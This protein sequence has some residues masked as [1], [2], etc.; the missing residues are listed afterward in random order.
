MYRIAVGWLTWEITESTVW[1]GII[2]F[3]ETFPLVIFSVIAG[4]LAD[5]MGYIRITV[6]AQ[7]ATAA[8]A[9][10]FAAMTLSGF[11]TIELVLIFALLK[12]WEIYL[13]IHLNLL[14]WYVFLVS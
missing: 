9:V 8:V 11:K 10:I 14:F 12:Y 1:L 3:A 4:A 7:T 6:I 13:I 5:R 2:A